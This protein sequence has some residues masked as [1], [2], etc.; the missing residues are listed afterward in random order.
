FGSF[1]LPI[2][3]KPEVSAKQVTTNMLPQGIHRGSQRGRPAR[4]Q[5]SQPP[6]EPVP[7]PP[8][9]PVFSQATRLR[10]SGLARQRRPF[11]ASPALSAISP[12]SRSVVSACGPCNLLRYLHHNCTIVITLASLPESG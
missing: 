6:P 11:R 12:V 8:R 10:L 2:A 3:I 7:T 1:V 5:E 4:I 9:T